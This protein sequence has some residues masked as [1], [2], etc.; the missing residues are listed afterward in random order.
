M[1]HH[2]K[3]WAPWIIGAVIIGIIIGWIIEHGMIE[4]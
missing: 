3:N 2:I 4:I 1:I